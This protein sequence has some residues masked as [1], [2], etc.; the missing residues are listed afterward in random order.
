MIVVNLW[1]AAREPRSI[2]SVIA[3]SDATAQSMAVT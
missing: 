2:N 1:Q 3:E